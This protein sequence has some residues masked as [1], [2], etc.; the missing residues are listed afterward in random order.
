MISF[1]SI[2]FNTENAWNELYQVEYKDVSRNLF[3]KIII[4]IIICQISTPAVDLL[5]RLPWRAWFEASFP[6]FY[7]SL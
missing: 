4:I 2:S 5:S 6:P 1:V 3:R 7:L